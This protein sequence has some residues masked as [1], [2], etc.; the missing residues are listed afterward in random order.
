MVYKIG[1]VSF[2]EAAV[3]LP[4]LGLGERLHGHSYKVE[5]EVAGERLDERGALID[6]AKL[7]A[8]LDRCLKKLHFQYLNELEPFKEKSPTC[9]NIARFVFENLKKD[10]EISRLKLSVRVWENELMWGSYG[11]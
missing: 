2:F 7:K 6:L 5:A 8:K 11:E 9:E 10:R 3:K 1:A 4:G